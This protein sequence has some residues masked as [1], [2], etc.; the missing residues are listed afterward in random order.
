MKNKADIDPDKHEFYLKE[1]PFAGEE[2]ETGRYVLGRDSE[3]AYSYRIGHP[4][5]QNIISF[6]K[7]QELTTGELIFDYTQTQKKISILEELIGKSGWLTVV[8]LTISSLETEDYLI[9]GGVMDAGNELDPEQARRFFSLPAVIMQP[10]LYFPQEKKLELTSIINRQKQVILERN[11][12]RNANYFEQEIEKLDK[13][14]EDRKTSLEIKLKDLDRIIKEKKAEAKKIL[15]LE[16]KVAAHREIKELEKRRNTLR[17]T[18]YEE[19]D[20]V[21]EEKEKLISEIE[22]R[23]HQNTEEEELFTIRWSII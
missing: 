1:K 16:E 19:Q 8:K 2:I 6:C 14:A 10:V 17:Y 11:L 4:L 20:R 13:W 3:K 5:A 23:L 21:D 15:K 18:L 7:E 12:E 22:A 9:F